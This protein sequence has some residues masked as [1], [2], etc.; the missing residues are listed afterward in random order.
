M[1][2][3]ACDRGGGN[4]RAIHLLG[5]PV[6]RYPPTGIENAAESFGVATASAPVIANAIRITA[7]MYEGSVTIGKP[8]IFA[9][10][11]DAIG[12]YFVARAHF[13]CLRE[14]NAMAKRIKRW[15]VKHAKDTQPGRSPWHSMPKSPSGRGQTGPDLRLA[16]RHREHLQIGP[17]LSSHQMIKLPTPIM[18]D[19]TTFTP[20]PREGKSI[21]DKI[22]RSASASRRVFKDRGE[23]RSTQK[24]KILGRCGRALVTA[25]S[26]E[27]SIG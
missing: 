4:V 23:A 6:L 16:V 8:P 3:I 9:L 5:S 12:R 27:R 11:R 7:A 22:T 2:N 25:A 20:R 19:L 18:P 13:F 26:R 10:R 1:D 14:G 21:R 17:L 24:K 15:I